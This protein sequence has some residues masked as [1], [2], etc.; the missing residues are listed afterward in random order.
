EVQ[1]VVERGVR[2]EEVVGTPLL[3][4]DRI[5]REP[6]V[7][8]M[9]QV[10]ARP[11]RIRNMQ[12]AIGEQSHEL[13]ECQRWLLV[14]QGAPRSLLSGHVCHSPDRENP[15]SALPGEAWGM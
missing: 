15:P 4:G 13:V 11:V 9:T 5:R 8:D 12:T 10:S 2:T 7:P 6:V 14:V 3:E 1:H